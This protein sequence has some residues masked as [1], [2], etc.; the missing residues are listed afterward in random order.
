MRY[1]RLL[2]PQHL[3]S[4]LRQRAHPEHIRKTYTTLDRAITLRNKPEQTRNMSSG[5][6]LATSHA[7]R[8]AAFI[9]IPDVC[10]RQRPD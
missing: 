2:T 1:Q 3:Q 9:L 10:S 4:S 6:F 8:T 7:P 5:P